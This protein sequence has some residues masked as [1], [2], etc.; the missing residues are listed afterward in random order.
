MYKGRVFLWPNCTLKAKVLHLVH[1]SPLGGQA[2]FLKSYHRLKQDFFWHGMK[3]DLKIHIKEC[4][5]CQQMK[6]KTCHPAGLLQ[7]LPIPDKPWSAVS[8]D[9][10]DGLPRSQ[11]MDVIMVVVDRL[12]KYVH[13]IAL[14]HPYSAAKVAHLFAQHVFKLHGMPTSLVYDRDPIFTA[15]FWA[16]LMQLQGVQLAMST[17]YHPQTDGQTKVVNKSLE[18]YLRSFSADRPSEWYDWLY[19]AEFWFNTNYHTATKLTPFEALY[20]TAPPRLLDYI[21]STTQ[22]AAVDTLLHSRQ[23]ILSLLKQNLVAAQARMKQHSD[24]HRTEREFQIGD[25]VYLRLQPYKQQSVAYRASHKLSPRFFGPFKILQR[26]GLVAYRLDL[27][28]SS[29]IHPVFHVTCLKAKLG[30]NSI[31]LP[32]LPYVTLLTLYFATCI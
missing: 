10:I 23:Q 5:V 16:E 2:G 7:P 3:S 18:H 19:L 31:P 9:F 6:S 14:S 28:A 20:G 29:C 22:V 12:T 24:L 30:H 25:W 1:D 27:P 21:P 26:V 11:R 17:A 32:S 4:D 8:M 15:K 13:F